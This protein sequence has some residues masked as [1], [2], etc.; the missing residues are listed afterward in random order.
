LLQQTTLL[1][2][3]GEHGEEEENKEEKKQCFAHHFGDTVAFYCSTH[4][5]GPWQRF[6]DQY[7]SLYHFLD[8]GDHPRPVDSDEVR[9]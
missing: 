7:H 2:R 8:P 9:R 3:R 5:K 4:Q 6:F 1:L